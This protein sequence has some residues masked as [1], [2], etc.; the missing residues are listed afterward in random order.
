MINFKKPEQNY[1]IL[2]KRK[3][4]PHLQAKRD[5]TMP[6]PNIKINKALVMILAGSE[7]QCRRNA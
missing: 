4:Y 1:S 6:Q 3:R 5:T 2:L 7:R